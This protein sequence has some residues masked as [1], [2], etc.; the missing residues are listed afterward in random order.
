MNTDKLSKITGIALFTLLAIALI[1]I[2]IQLEPAVWGM[3][4]NLAH[5]ILNLI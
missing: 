4:L 5:K 1:R 2:A 3:Y